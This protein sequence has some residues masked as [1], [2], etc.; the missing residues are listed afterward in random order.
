MHKIFGD[1]ENVSYTTRI[2]AYIIP[3]YNNKIGIIQTPKGNF[4]IGGG[5]DTNETDEECLKRECLE[6]IGCEI[7]IYNKICSAETFTHH[8]KIGY[9][10]PIQAYY[11]GLV[12]EQ[13][14]KPIEND[15]R[16]VW[17]EFDEV[18]NIMY[19][20]MQNWAIQQCIKGLE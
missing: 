19:S 17:L 20:E 10:H 18:Q 12:K 8:E 13:I 6:E 2:G 16:L 1:I 15:H 3:I 11:S 9:F 14:A 5:K 4:L 7:E